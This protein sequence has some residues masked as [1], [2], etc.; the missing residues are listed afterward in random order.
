M[1]ILFQLLLQLRHKMQIGL[2]VDGLNGC[3]VDSSRANAIYPAAIAISYRMRTTRR[4]L[5]RSLT[6]SDV[7]CPRAR[8]WV[9][10]CCAPQAAREEDGRRGEKERSKGFS[11]N[12]ARCA[13]NKEA[14]PSRTQISF[15]FSVSAVKLTTQL[16]VPTA[17]ETASFE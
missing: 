16:R 13:S 2:F 4:E 12:C 5:L 11:S 15:S 7:S 14:T 1:S 9:Q 17:A 6:S 3:N 8:R 10:R